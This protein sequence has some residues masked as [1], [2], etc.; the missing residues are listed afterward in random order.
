MSGLPASRSASSQLQIE[1]IAVLQGCA[2][3]EGGLSALPKL[4]PEAK[5]GVGA[6][7]TVAMVQNL[8]R[9]VKN[10]KRAV[11]SAMELC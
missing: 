1:F 9:S 11:P 3:A 2:R 6:H 8:H 10:R 4:A 7:G 5:S